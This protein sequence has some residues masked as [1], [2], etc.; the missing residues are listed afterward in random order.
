MKE[1]RGKVVL[2][3]FWTYTCINCE[4]TL[5]HVEAW[6]NRY[7]NDG[8]VVVGVHTPEFSFEHVVSNVRRESK[9]L[10]VDYPVAVDDNYGTWNA[11]GNEYWPAEYLIDSTGTIRHV[12]IGEGDYSGTEKLIRQLLAAAKPGAALPQS[13]DVKDTTPDTFPQPDG[14]DLS[15]CESAPTA[16]GAPS[17]WASARTWCR[18]PR[19]WLPTNSP[20][21]ERGRSRRR[22]PQP[23]APNARI[24]LN[25]LAQAV[26]LDIGGTGT[27]TATSNGV[28]KTFKVSGAPDIYTVVSQKSAVRH[29][30]DISVSPGLTA[31]SFTFG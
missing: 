28:T 25:Y 31:Y 10:G 17:R 6:Y 21:R 4:R 22:G 23:P 14:R 27:I 9:T 12:S 18:F 7:K 16:T 13:T 5:P 19:L 3:D 29:T 11:Y 8:L 15:G 26:Y 20:S 30:V 1:L 2:V 24:R